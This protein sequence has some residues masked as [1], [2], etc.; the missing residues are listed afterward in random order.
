MLPANPSFE[1]ARIAAVLLPGV[2]SYGAS[3]VKARRFVEWKA[4][5]LG[6]IGIGTALYRPGNGAAEVASRTAKIL[7]AYD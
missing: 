6:A 5:G 3:R 4:G 7:A 1:V 2:P